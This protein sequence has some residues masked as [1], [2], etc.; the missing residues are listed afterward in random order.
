M[1]NVV[2]EWNYPDYVYYENC[3]GYIVWNII[4]PLALKVITEE[5][6]DNFS[7][8]L[9]LL[10]K[11]VHGLTI[12]FSNK[13]N[14]EEIQKARRVIWEDRENYTSLIAYLQDLSTFFKL[15]GDSR[16]NEL[17]EFIDKYIDDWFAYDPEIHSQ[18]R[19]ADGRRV[20]KK[21]A[22]G[23]RPPTEEELKEFNSNIK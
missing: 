4:R 8:E 9:G 21:D 22:I 17:I 23:V 12:D 19:Y 1:S 10:L 6:Y 20:L 16:F 18:Y 14:R 5:E 15:L 3:S 11:K 7:E 2:V 13:E